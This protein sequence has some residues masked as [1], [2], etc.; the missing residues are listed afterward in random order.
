MAGLRCPVVHL[1]ERAILV[2]SVCGPFLGGTFLAH[3]EEGLGDGQAVVVS[4]KPVV[5]VVVISV[6][7]IMDAETV[8]SLIERDGVVVYPEILDFK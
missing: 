8:D 1:I 5:L 6:P 2:L 3:P 7:A 4:V